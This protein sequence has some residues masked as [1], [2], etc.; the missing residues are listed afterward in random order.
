MTYICHL[1]GIFVPET[2]FA[3]VQYLLQ[4]ID[5]WWMCARI[6]SLYVDYSK[7]VLGQI[8]MQGGRHICSEAS[9]NNVECVYACGH[10]HI[11]HC[12]EDI[13]T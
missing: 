5:F 6:L 2:L 9:A 7:N 12:I 8:Y 13:L 1:R 11:F 10:G 3:V 4:F